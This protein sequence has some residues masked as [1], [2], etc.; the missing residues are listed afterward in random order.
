MKTKE[1]DDV[2][3]REKHIIKE[4]IKNIACLIIAIIILYT[5]FKMDLFP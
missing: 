5:F 2:N 4:V 1:V 3:A